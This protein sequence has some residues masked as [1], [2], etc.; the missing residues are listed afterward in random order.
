MGKL[1]PAVT[2]RVM[3]GAQLSMIFGQL[4]YEGPQPHMRLI[5]PTSG[6]LSD[7]RIAL[8]AQRLKLIE[9]EQAGRPALYYCRDILVDPRQ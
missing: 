3:R 4:I 6:E 7:A 5:D 1:P 8:D 2:A 9:E